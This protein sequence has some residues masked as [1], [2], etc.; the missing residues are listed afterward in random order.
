M[1]GAGVRPERRAGS[2]AAAT[3]PASRPSFRHDFASTTATN[4]FISLVNVVTGVLVARLLNPAGRGELAAILNWPTFLGM[5]TTLGMT[6]A[7]VFYPARQRTRAG[8]YLGTG[9]VVSLSASA[10]FVAVGWVLMPV[11][12]AAQ[13][14]SVVAGARWYLLQVPVAAVIG[15][16]IGPLRGIGDVRA[17][18]VL[19]SVPTLLWLGTL[20]VFATRGGG[21]PEPATVAISFVAARAVLAPV[22]VLFVRRRLRQPLRPD[23]SLAPSLLR[24]GLPSALAALPTTL[25]VRLDQLLIAAFLP[26]G[27]LGLYAV[28][29]SWSTLSSPVMAAFGNVL[30]PRVAEHDDDEARAALA[31]RGVRTA[32]MLSVVLTTVA[33]LLTPI[34]LPLLFGHRF[35]VAVPTAL[36][37]TV[38][39]AAFGVTSVQQEVLRGLGRP[40]AVL[41]SQLAGLAVTVAG[42][43]VTMPTGGLAWIAMASVAGYGSAALA[44]LVNLVR[45]TGLPAGAFVLPRPEDLHAVRAA[46]P[47]SIR[48][49]PVRGPLP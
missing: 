46:L 9:L 19:R 14:A 6:E 43:A 16:V 39:G 7:L 40:A 11:L 24:F 37:L 44:L 26:P 27:D 13:D 28:A 12:L 23:L 1:T 22:A 5:L 36:V 49:R 20:V 17:W 45:A 8:R 25:N 4:L 47:T 42:L 18:N 38:A 15:L 30:F 10:G 48:R 32:I 3:S 41:W 34:G 31:A 33:L 21:R 2:A 29:V 35:D